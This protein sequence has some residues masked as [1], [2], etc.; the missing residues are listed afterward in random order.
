MTEPKYII[1]KRIVIDQYYNP[2]FGDNRI[3]QCGHTYERHFDGYEDGRF[4]GCKYCACDDFVE[5]QVDC[6][7]TI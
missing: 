3:C 4:V 6:N 2:N 7:S 5:Q 1:Q